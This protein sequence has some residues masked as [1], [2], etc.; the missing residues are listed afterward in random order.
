MRAGR[1]RCPVSMMA[2]LP[3]VP[4][5]GYCSRLGAGGRLDPPAGPKDVVAALWEGGAA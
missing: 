5:S 1:G 3:G 2:R 4:R